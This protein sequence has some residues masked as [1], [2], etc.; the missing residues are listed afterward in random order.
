MLYSIP[1]PETDVPTAIAAWSIKAVIY[2]DHEQSTH[3]L[4]GYVRQERAGRVS[5]AIQSFDQDQRLIQTQSGRWYQLHGC[6]GE[7][8]D[9]E[10]VWQHWKNFHTAR[11][12]Q[13]VTNQ[14]WSR[15]L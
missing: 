4:I 1:K 3:H 12:E 11:D 6:P 15:A 14:Y 10:Y 8:P 9:A 5:S 7:H 13:D 2:D